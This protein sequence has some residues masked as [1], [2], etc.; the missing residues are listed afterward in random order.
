MLS[1]LALTDGS[2]GYRAFS[3]LLAADDGQ[4]NIRAR[5][6]TG[7]IWR[8]FLD[9]ATDEDAYYIGVA[10]Y[11][12]AN[13]QVAIAASRRAAEAGDTRAQSNLGVPAGIPGPAGP[14]RGS[15][16]VHSG[17]PSRPPPGTRSAK[18]IGRRLG[19]RANPTHHNQD[20]VS[21]A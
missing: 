10:A 21:S 7:T 18:A 12:R 1:T 8:S 3:Y 14:N 11:Q 17:G 20:H 2:R 19:R 6:V 16:L 13:S 15:Q 4:G 9:C 5:P